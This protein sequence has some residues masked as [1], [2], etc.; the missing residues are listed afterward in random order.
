MVRSGWRGSIAA[1]VW[2]LGAATLAPAGA[3]AEVFFANPSD[4]IDA[5][6]ATI[7]GL[8]P[9]DELVLSGGTYTLGGR[10]S[11]AIAGTEAQP[12]VIRAADGETPHLHRPNASQNIVDIDDAQHVVI[13]GIEF[14]GG[15]AGIRI[16][17]ARFLTIEQC[18]IHDTGDVALRANDSGVTY[19]SLRILRNHIHHTNNTGEGMYLGCNSAGCEVVDSL[20]EGNYVHHTNQPSV[21]Q[22][23]GIELKEG[24]AGNVIRDNV[25]HDTN[26][27][28]ILTYASNGAQNTIERNVMWNCGDHGIQA[29]ADAI[30]RNN[31][32]LGANADGIAMQPHQAGSP[33]NLVVVHNT[34]LNAG[35]DAMSL[36][37]ISGAVVIANNALYSQGGRAFYANGTSGLTFEG[38]VGVG[39]SNPSLASGD[40]GLDFVNA[41]FAGAPPIDVFPNAG[42]ALVGS[43]STDHVA[44]DDFNGTPRVGTPDVGA[45]AYASA[46]NPG[47]T[48]TEAFK[49]PAAS[50]PGSGGAGGSATGGTGGTASGTGGAS[51]GQ[52][53]SSG[54]SGCAV[55]P[56]REVTNDL[57]WLFLIAALLRRRAPLG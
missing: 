49:T 22:G 20:I 14:S 18:E 42:S 48:L 21:S 45:Y 5:V 51:G 12:I 10:F 56:S 29:A 40:L 28:C 36:R 44:P 33:S 39:E 11:F 37:G 19:E 13:R 46:G 3:S 38:N 6:E 30:I 55:A 16:S 23:D 52:A 25:I 54:S 4:D 24:S 26:Y 1:A 31:I 43:G 32:V 34:V 2:V 57:G 41:S 50:G 9:G 17:G 35:G 27:P 47:W 15:S 7:S 53:A 8:G